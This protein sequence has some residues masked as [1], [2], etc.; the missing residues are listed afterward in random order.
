MDKIL[1]VLAS[2]TGISQ[3]ELKG[4]LLKPESEELIEGFDAEV[5]SLIGE[6]IKSV[7]EQQ[8][9]RGIRE[10]ATGLEKTLKEKFEISDNLQGNELIERIYEVSQE[11]KQVEPSDLEP[12]KIK[13]HP[14]F[15]EEIKRLKE[16]A[17]KDVDKV[18]SEY[19]SF[20]NEVQTK[21][22]KSF[23][24]S[25]AVKVLKDSRANLGNAPEDE[26]KRIG[27]FKRMLNLNEF[28]IDGEGDE[29]KIVVVDNEGNI[30]TDSNYNP[31]DFESYIKDLNPFGFHEHDP[32]KNGGGAPRGTNGSGGTNEF[33]KF[34]DQSE[35]MEYIN[36]NRKSMTKEQ[37]DA[38]KEH[39]STLN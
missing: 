13:A 19:D 10:A 15:Q 11:K 6:K 33:A 2:V 27:A 37:F 5:K 32:G 18:R 31:I 35:L 29:K 24:Y 26:E 25:K 34:K 28:K 38:A 17:K 3:T 4:K 20:K 30:K 9:K 16:N 22:L 39:L 36:K 8:Y 14:V 21:E 23:L 1:D 7:G 12:E